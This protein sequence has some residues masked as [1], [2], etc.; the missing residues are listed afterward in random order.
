MQKLEVP[1][2]ISLKLWELLSSNTI[3]F[4]INYNVVFGNSICK[5]PSKING[6]LLQN[7][8]CIFYFTYGYMEQPDVAVVFL[9]IAGKLD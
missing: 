2:E 1:P 6:K 9:F 3:Y 7:A 5:L 8:L 4:I